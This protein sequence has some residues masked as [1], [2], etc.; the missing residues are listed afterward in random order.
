MA[1]QGSYHPGSPHLQTKESAQL[2][3]IDE[4]QRAFMLILAI[5]PP[6]AGKCRR[7]RVIGV[8]ILPIPGLVLLLCCSHQARSAI[9]PTPAS[10][11]D[12]PALEVGDELPDNPSA[13]RPSRRSWDHAGNDAPWR[14]N[15]TLNHSNHAYRRLRALWRSTELLAGARQI[16][17]LCVPRPGWLLSVSWRAGRSRAFPARQCSS[18]TRTSFV[19]SGS[20]EPD[21]G[22]R[23][24]RQPPA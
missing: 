18:A 19:A 7:V 15:C 24:A 17:R 14:T 9:A 20:D 4:G 10:G 23:D 5:V 21:R 1:F 11:P 13:R 12:G 2:T 8:L 16:D 3:R 6:C 22:G